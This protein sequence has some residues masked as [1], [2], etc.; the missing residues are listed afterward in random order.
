MVKTLVCTLIFN[1]LTLSAMAAW[2]EV[3]RESF[4]VIVSIPSADFYVL[5]VDPQLVQ[6]EQRLPFNTV[7]SQLSPLRAF[8]DVKNANGAIGARLGEE[9]YLSNGRDRID[10]RVTFNKVEL[11]LDSVQ[12][13]SAAQAR[14]GQRV[15]LE[16]AAIKPAD[17]YLPGEYLGTVH[18]MFDAIAP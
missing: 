13:V 10:L 6:R 16:I 1:S 5:P 14:P 7:T 11:T 17:D 8:F 15:G 18:M 2:G 3:Q 9:A 12:V 4:E